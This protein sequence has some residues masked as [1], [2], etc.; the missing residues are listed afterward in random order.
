MGLANPSQWEERL[1]GVVGGAA[2]I[3]WDTSWSTVQRS[4]PLLPWPLLSG[5]M[6]VGWGGST[7]VQCQ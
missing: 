7:Q 5:S 2:G 1:V 4:A 6:G 3:P